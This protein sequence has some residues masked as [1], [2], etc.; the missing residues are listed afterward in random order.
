MQRLF[1]GKVFSLMSGFSFVGQRTGSCR[2]CV[3]M[4][5]CALIWWLLYPLDCLHLGFEGLQPLWIVFGR[6]KGHCLFASNTANKEDEECG[7]N[8]KVQEQV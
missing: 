8:L 4:D 5:G 6:V 2:K 1:T 7:I 3:R